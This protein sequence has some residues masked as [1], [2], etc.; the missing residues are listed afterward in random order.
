MRL[1]WAGL[2]LAGCGL[3]GV[4]ADGPVAA[5]PKP[6]KEACREI[7]YS[8][9]PGGARALLKKLKCD[10]RAGSN[11]DWGSAVDLN[12]DGSPEYQFCCHEAGHGPCGAVLIGRVG[13]QWKDLTAKDGLLGFD[14]ACNLFVVLESRHGGFRDV[15]LPAQCAAPAQAGACTPVRWQYDGRRYRASGAEAPRKAPAPPLAR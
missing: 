12:G 11:Y 14:G 8:D 13:G 10:V 2:L 6:A 9:L 15:C 1:R 5:C 7:T 4:A 3:P